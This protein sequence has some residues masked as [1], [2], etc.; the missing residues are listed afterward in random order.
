MLMSNIMHVATLCNFVKC[1]GINI[2]NNNL[3]VNKKSV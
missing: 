3:V 1:D 2:L